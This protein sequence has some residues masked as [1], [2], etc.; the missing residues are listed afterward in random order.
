[1]LPPFW[2]NQYCNKLGTALLGLCL[3]LTSFAQ[4]T[5]LPTPAS[6]DYPGILESLEK[7]IQIDNTKFTKKIELLAK[8]GKS[9]S[10]TSGIT[11]L[12]LDPDF[13]NSIILHSSPSYVK[14]ASGSKCQFYDAI[15]NDLV[16]NAEGKLKNVLIS[17]VNKNQ[18]RDSA[19]VTKKDFINTVVPSECPETS[20][21]I[22][23]F[24]IKNL[25]KTIASVSFDHPTSK[26]QCHNTYV[27]WLNSSKTPYFCKLHEF[28]KEVKTGGGDPK[29]MAQRQAI[30]KILEQKL[31]LPQRDYLESLCENFD[32]EELFCNDFL[33]VSFWSKIAMGSENRI[34]AE[35]ICE[36]VMGVKTLNDA[37]LKQCL[38]K[39]KKENDLCLY[40]GGRGQGLQPSPQCDNL[41]TALNH[42][43]LRSDYKDCPNSSDQQVITNMARILLNIS[44]EKISPIGGACSTLSAGVTFE[45]NKRFNND[46]GW[47]LEACYNDEL[48]EKE[49][50]YKTFFG[51]YGDL[52]ESYPKVVSNILQKTRGADQS[53]KCTMVDSEDYNPLLLEYKSGCYIIYERSK[54]FISQCKNK[55]IYNDRAIDHIKVK[56]RVSLDYFPS[57]ILNER[58]SQHYLL[59]RDYRQNGRTL[60][61]IMS[62]SSFFKKSK[63]GIIHGVGCAE[64]LLPSF[65]KSRA[66]NQCTPLPFIIDGMIKENDK[67]VFITR[68]AID[69]LQA[70]RMVNWSLIFSAV[71]SYQRYHPLKLWTLYGL[72]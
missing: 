50:C 27:E 18:E 45:F 57:S 30:S 25:D 63:N 68:T 11:S 60:N 2:P 53:L 19:I 39:M 72:D 62:I 22:D 47:K 4:T 46:E 7:L 55:I 38:A 23:Q 44:K 36:Q 41:A 5:P 14:L 65:F 35:D 12:E 43:L 13:L 71:K 69:S 59:T 1:M 58:F 3:S 31:T 21:L 15:I 20:K 10:S 26:D 48:A 17:Y 34:Y 32:N 52:P 51:T 40:A 67:T 29:D 16:K 56:N 61:S 49:V 33:S 64:D 9:L 54:C 8:G 37:Q 42:S 70:P 28:I 24:Q 66:F 6:V